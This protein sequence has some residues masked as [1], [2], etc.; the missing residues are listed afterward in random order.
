MT[1][2]Y[3]NM[4]TTF[5]IRRAQHRAKGEHFKVYKNPRFGFFLLLLLCL[6]WLL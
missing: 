5:R 6:L 2:A 4:G 3:T 1:E